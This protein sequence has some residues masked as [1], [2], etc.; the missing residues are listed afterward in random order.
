MDATQIFR[1]HDYELVCGAKATDSGKFE[2]TAVVSKCIWPSRPRTLAMQRGD[3]LTAA[4]AVESAHAQA[5][6]W[7]ANFG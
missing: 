2:P 3:F 6:V 5:L 7:I 4:A 1:V